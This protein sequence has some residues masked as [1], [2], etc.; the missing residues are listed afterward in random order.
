MITGSQ[1]R[2]ARAM[3]KW[4]VSELAKRTGIGVAVIL[5]AERVDS[6]PSVTLHQASTM[7]QAFERAGVRFGRGR[8][9]MMVAR[10]EEP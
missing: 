6:T 5:R 10:T 4:D 7:Q 8:G 3:L 2:E 9:V 1:I